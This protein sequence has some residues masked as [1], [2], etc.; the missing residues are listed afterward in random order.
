MVEQSKSN[1][2]VPEGGEKRVMKFDKAW[3]IQSR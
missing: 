2:K 3:F 1:K